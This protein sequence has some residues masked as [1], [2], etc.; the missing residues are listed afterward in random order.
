MIKTSRS[1]SSR[2]DRVRGVKHPVRQLY[3]TPAAPART[4]YR[5]RSVFMLFGE[6]LV[7]GIRKETV[8]EVIERAY[9]EAAACRLCFW[10]LACCRCVHFMACVLLLWTCMCS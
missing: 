8:T 5:P 9:D 3:L 10:L 4:D 1:G 2:T 6:L 7:R